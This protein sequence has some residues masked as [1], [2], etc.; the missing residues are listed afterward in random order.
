M[1]MKPDLDADVARWL[2]DVVLT[3]VNYQGPASDL[4]PM[5][6][7]HGRAV[8]QLSGFIPAD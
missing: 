7:R 6:E 8:E 3:A 2:R 1:T 5:L 4:Q